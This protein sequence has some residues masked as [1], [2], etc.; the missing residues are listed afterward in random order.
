MAQ[1]TLSPSVT[2]ASLTPTAPVDGIPYATAVPITL[3]EADLNGG[4][5]VPT[6]PIPVEYG[7]VISAVVQL[8][9]NGSVV[10]NNTYVVM[11]TDM[12]DGLWIDVAWVIWTGNQ[13]TATFVL[14]GGGGGGF[15]AG[16]YQQTRQSNSPPT[17]QA[18]GTSG[19]PIAGRVRFVGKSA[20]VGG[21]SSLFGT[22]AQISATIKYKVFNPR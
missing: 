8:S 18:N 2:N 5:N 7:Q 13:G 10:G 17:P 19:V 9:F 4:T 11:Q 16:T 22:S 3:T 12:G 20:F 6:G 21:S 15:V 1:Q 14:T